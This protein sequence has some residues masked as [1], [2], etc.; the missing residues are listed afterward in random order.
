MVLENSLHTYQRRKAII[1]LAT[2][3]EIYNSD[4]PTD[5]PDNSGTNIVGVSNHCITGFE[6]HSMR[7]NSY[8]ATT[9]G[10]Q[11]LLTGQNMSFGENQ[12]LLFSSSIAKKWPLMICYYTQ[13][14]GLAQPEK[15]PLSV[16]TNRDSKLDNVLRVRDFRTLNTNKNVFIKLLP[17]GLRDLCR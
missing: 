9:L 17:L 6:A 5:M 1:N 7:Q 2:N 10:G 4:L 11:G 15:L 3:P 12:I 13:R 14:Y 8:L 16:V